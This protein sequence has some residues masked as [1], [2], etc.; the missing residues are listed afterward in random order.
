MEFHVLATRGVGG[1]RQYRIPGMGVTASGRIIAVYDGRP[2]LDDLPSPVDVVIRTS[3]DLGK[4]WSDQKVLFQ[5]SGVMGYGDPSVII[6][7]TVGRHGRVIVMAQRTEIAGF[8]ESTLGID[9]GDPNIA[10]VVLAQSDDNGE[11]WSHRFITD[12]VKDDKT[13]GIFATSGAGGRVT[14][15]AHAGRLLHTFVL[16]QGDKLS[17]V[18]AYSDDHGDTWHLGAHIPGGNE[19]AAVGLRDG[20]I[21]AHSRARPHR[22]V[23]RSSDGGITLDSLEPDLGLPD[24]SDNGSLMTLKNGD[25]IASH[26]HDSDLRRNTVVK[27]SRDGGKTWPLAVVLEEGS[28]SYSTAA[29]LSDGSIGVLFERLGYTEMVFARFTIV[30]FKPTEDVIKNQIDANGIE[31]NIALRY[32]RPGKKAVDRQFT[33]RKIPAVDMSVFGSSERKEVGVPGGNASGEALYTR[34][35]LDELLGPITP[36]LHEGNEL[37]WSGRLTNHSSEILTDVSITNSF[38][39]EALTHPQLLSKEKFVFLDCRQTISRSD[40]EKSHLEVVFFWSATKGG[41]R[42]SGS[43]L[44]TL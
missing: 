25:L 41:N 6:D 11:M 1:Y 22:L 34:E 3:D 23:A 28:S 20:S 8:F 2:D 27:K 40:S 9:E 32:I 15:G 4:S 12:Q 17:S 26:N 31:F 44:Q 38:N 43:F 30:E 18:L 39:N 21:V 14:H 10:Q 42:I 29:E 16:R 36:G 13:P 24:P 19:S 5:S 35:E 7:P 33:D 37:R